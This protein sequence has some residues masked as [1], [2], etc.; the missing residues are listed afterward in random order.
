VDPPK[1]VRTSFKLLQFKRDPLPLMAG[2][3]L[4]MGKREPGPGIL[5]MADRLKVDMIVLA[6]ARTEHDLATVTLYVYDV[7]LKKLMKGPVTVKPSTDFPKEK[8]KPAV[9]RLFDGIRLDGMKPKPK[10]KPTKALWKRMNVGW[11]K[12]RRSKAFWPVV[13]GVAG[14]I[15]TGV[16]VGLAVGLSNR[17]FQ[18]RGSRHVLAYPLAR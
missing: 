5:G 8:V 6:R 15:V 1:L 11:A 17:G 2:A 13:G 7:R 10:K 18:P 14:A 16:V 12:F 3:L 9:R 4:E